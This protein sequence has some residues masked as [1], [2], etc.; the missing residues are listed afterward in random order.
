VLSLIANVPLRV[1]APSYADQF[2]I[3]SVADRLR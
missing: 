3:T 1:G 2:D